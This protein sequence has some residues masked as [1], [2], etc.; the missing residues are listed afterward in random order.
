MDKYHV[1]AT[2]HSLNYLPE[3]VAGWNGY[4]ADEGLA[5]SVSVPKPWDQVLDDLN[6]GAAQAALGGIWVPSMYRG[7][8]TSYTPFAK[9]SGRAPLAL[10][11][12]ESPDAFTWESLIGRVV[13]MKGSNG[14]SVGLYL[15]MVLRENG[16][17]PNSVRYVQDLDGVML[18]ELFL[19]GLGDYLFIDQLS[20]AHLAKT[21]DTSIVFAAAAQGGDIPWSVYYAPG[22]LNGE[23]PLHA[24]FARAISRGMEWLQERDPDQYA[25]QLQQAFPGKDPEILAALAREFK[26]HGMWQNARIERESYDRWQVGIR[27][28]HLIDEPI[29]LDDFVEDVVNPRSGA[30]G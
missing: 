13:L 5:Y 29:V 2:G 27:D 11:G 28:G 14:A 20:A 24:R 23:R 1:S 19:G 16:I 8:S 3:Y 6:S 30:D 26:D 17:D 18:G 7:R 10:L 4:F 22:P 25:E 12:R 15:K 9:V 21:S